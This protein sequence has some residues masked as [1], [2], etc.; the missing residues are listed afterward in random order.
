MVC[1]RKKFIKVITSIAKLILL[2]PRRNLY[3]PYFQLLQKYTHNA[4]LS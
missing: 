2:R 3:W 1:V 4:V